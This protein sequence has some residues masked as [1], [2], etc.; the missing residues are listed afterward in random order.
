[1]WIQSHRVVD[2]IV[3]ELC[4]SIVQI[5]A[6][7]QSEDA[8]VWA[9]GV[10]VFG[11]LSDVVELGSVHCEEEWVLEDQLVGDVVVAECSFAVFSNRRCR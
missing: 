4:P 5:E 9:V 11:F 10:Q 7:W 1:M 8:V 3:W 6:S 2:R